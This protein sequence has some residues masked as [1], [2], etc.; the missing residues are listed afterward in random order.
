MRIMVIADQESKRLYDFYEPSKLE[1][2][3]LIIS[4]GDLKH[5][6]LDFFAS[7]ARV[8]VLYVLGNH[9]NADTL[10]NCGCICIEDCIFEYQ[11][12][13]IL[14]LGGSMQYLPGAPNQYTERQMRRRIQK[15]RWKIRKKQGFDILVT[16]APAFE[17]NDLP[18]LPHRGFVCFK[19]LLDRY[20]PGLFLH[21]HIHAT[22]GTGF[23]RE[24]QY[25]ETRIINGFEYHVIDYPD[26]A[27]GADGKEGT[28]LL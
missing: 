14:G 16:H 19:E 11:G 21:G 23:K 13:R 2:I 27:S 15:M 26:P 8:P 5:E 9:D 24:D 4:C 22:Y 17:L 12:L 25:H 20:R 28:K 10:K 7:V 18:D 3:D 1:G 6:Y